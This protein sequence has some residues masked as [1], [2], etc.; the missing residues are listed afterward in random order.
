MEKEKTRGK[1]G[2]IWLT[3]FKT[4]QV[5]LLREIEKELKEKY[6][7]NPEKLR[8]IDEITQFLDRKISELRVRTIYNYVATLVSISRKYPEFERMIPSLNEF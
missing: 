3:S 7:N 5:I 6:K 8:E 2:K 1:I 4:K